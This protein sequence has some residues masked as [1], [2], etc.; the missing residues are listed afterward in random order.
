MK[1]TYQLEDAD[2]MEATL[3]ITMTVGEWRELTRQ[4]SAAWPSW[5]F[6]SLVCD[7]IAGANEKFRAVGECK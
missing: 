1:A 4:Q 3:V 2:K 6:S 5:K 7:L